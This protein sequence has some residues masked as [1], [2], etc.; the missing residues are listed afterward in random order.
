M[1]FPGAKLQQLLGNEYCIDVGTSSG[2][3]S[4]KAVA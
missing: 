3:L 4:K 2:M 1:Y